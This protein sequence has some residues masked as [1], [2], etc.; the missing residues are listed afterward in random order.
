M[1]CFDRMIRR[2]ERKRWKT[3]KMSDLSV[4]LK[5]V[6]WPKHGSWPS[7]VKRKDQERLSLEWQKQPANFS[8][9]L[10]L[11]DPECF[12]CWL[13]QQNGC[14]ISQEIR[15]VR[16]RQMHT[17][18]VP[19]RP[20]YYQLVL[21]ISNLRRFHHITYATLEWKTENLVTENKNIRPK[22]QMQE[23]GS[24]SFQ[25][26]LP[27]VFKFSAKRAKNGNGLSWTCGPQGKT[28]K[29]LLSHST[30]VSFW[31]WECY[32]ICTHMFHAQKALADCERF[33]LQMGLRTHSMLKKLAP[34]LRTIS[35]MPVGILWDGDFRMRL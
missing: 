9:S 24:Y 27:C 35:W 21:F 10:P 14:G 15:F 22:W 11:Q 3:E 17:N 20:E 8:V 30:G 28:L 34:G 13:I 1:V 4:L 18:F 33:A 19:C 32:Q 6:I 2:N 7:K 16:F 31:M 25:T 23:K 12:A 5:K 29:I 26:W